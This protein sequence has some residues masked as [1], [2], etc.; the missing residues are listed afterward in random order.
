MEAIR[1]ELTGRWTIL[2]MEP[3]SLTYERFINYLNYGYNFKFAR[4]GDGE[5][6]AIFGKKGHNCDG[7]EYFPDLGAR[8]RSSFCKNIFT[9]IQPLT[10]TLPYAKEALKLLEG[11]NLV[12]ADAIHN[13]SIDGELHRLTEVLHGRDVVCVGS[14][15][16]SPLFDQ[17]IVIP[18][19]NCWLSYEKVKDK[20][21]LLIQRDKVVVLC[22]SMMSEVLI[23]DFEDE[24]ITMID[25]GSA[26]DPLVGKLSRR[27]HHKLKL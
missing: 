9:G 2:G 22:A 18:D 19:K 8:L 25:V 27:Y 3:S 20:L 7:H 10:L 15:H 24:D 23:K 21:E 4:Y 6:N 5:F 14:A 12:N 17:M 13:A 11:C 16:L 26:F 1:N